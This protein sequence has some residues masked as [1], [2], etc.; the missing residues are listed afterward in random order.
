V[1]RYTIPLN[2]FYRETIQADSR[3]NV[4]HHSQKNR[5]GGRTPNP[6]RAFTLIEL[7]VVIA[8]IAILA[9][10]LFP[11]FAQ[12]RS[13]ARQ[14]A[15]LSNMKQWGLGMM[16]YQQDYDELV[17]LMGYE[18]CLAAASQ[19]HNAI[20]PYIKNRGLL[21]CPGDP[22]QQF[23]RFDPLNPQASYLAND[24]LNRNVW[25][26]SCAT[27]QR[28]VVSQAAINS[29]A[30]TIFLAEGAAW[31]KWGGCSANCQN[32]SGNLFIAENH[33]ELITGVLSIP[34]GQ[35]GA[36]F[37]ASAR[38]RSTYE[39]APFH[40]G[41][42][43]FT[44]TDGHAKWFRTTNGEGA[45]KVSIINQTLPWVRHVAPSQQRERPWNATT[46]TEQDNSWF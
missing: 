29:P 14:T 19:W 21:K 35:A 26:G 6:R 11:V 7:L 41:G 25:G 22:S 27:L 28:N 2:C 37:M 1:N 9:A 5:V 42:A 40:N 13:K 8:I 38:H 31:G 46:R 32:T 20:Q 10:I 36:S 3:E 24:W 34:W 15:C 45:A 16:M 33:G 23:A 43:N 4:M 30:D 39:Y 17:P 12:A 44:F 18:G